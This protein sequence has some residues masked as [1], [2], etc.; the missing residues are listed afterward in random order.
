MEILELHRLNLTCVFNASN[1]RSLYNA[2]RYDWENIRLSC[3]AR[4]LRGI[5]FRNESWFWYSYL[6]THS[7]IEYE[8]GL[9]SEK[10]SL[11]RV[12]VDSVDRIIH[13][14]HKVPIKQ[15][16]MISEMLLPFMHEAFIGHLG[17]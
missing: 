12:Y 14:Y 15:Q 6:G 4:E 13:F 3:G 5:L 17:D 11:I 2:L 10:E 1:A 9:P 7:E 8:L 16:K